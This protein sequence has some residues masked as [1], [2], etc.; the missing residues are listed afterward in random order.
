MILA[1]QMWIAEPGGPPKE[2]TMLQY[3][4]CHSLWMEGWEIWKC[5]MRCLDSWD[6]YERSEFSEPRYLHLLIDKRKLHSLTWDI[7]FSLIN[8]NL[9][10]SDYLSPLLQSSVWPNSSPLPCLLRTVSLGYLR[11]CLPGTW[12][13]TFRLWLIFSWQEYRLLRTYLF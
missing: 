1:F 10:C 13:S 4:C 7:W 9:W 6:W 2:R 12:L 3:S 11:C 5:R 8:N